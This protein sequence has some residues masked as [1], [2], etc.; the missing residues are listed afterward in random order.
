[1]TSNMHID[2]PE[3]SER[4]VL[5]SSLFDGMW[6]LKLRSVGH[7]GPRIQL[8]RDLA[9]GLSDCRTTLLTSSQGRLCPQAGFKVL[10]PSTAPGITRAQEGPGS[11]DLWQK[12][13][14]G[15]TARG[16]CGQ[17]MEVAG[18]GA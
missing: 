11:H 18:S 15:S 6:T 13:E 14:V 9:L 12:P 2:L 5:S 1:M 10:A 3:H 16:W 8:R 17:E 4:Q 7:H